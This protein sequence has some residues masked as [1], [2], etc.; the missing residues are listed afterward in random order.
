MMNQFKNLMLFRLLILVIQSKKN[1]YETKINKIEK[2]TDHD[3]AQYITTS[4]FKLTLE[5]FASRLAQARL[6]SKNDI[7]NFVKKTDFDNKLKKVNKTKK[8]SNKTNHILVGNG[9]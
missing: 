5:N 2:I 7:A 1:D 3:N 9:F 6:V 8:N 4:E